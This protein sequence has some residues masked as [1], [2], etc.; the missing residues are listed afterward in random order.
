MTSFPRALCTPRWRRR[1]VL[2]AGLSAVLATA[3]RQTAV[4]AT[5]SRSMAGF[6]EVLFAIAGDLTIEQGTRE[7]LTVEAEPAVLPKITTDV[8]GRR[9][10][11][12][13]G[14]GRI[15]TQQPI[16][17]RLGVRNL[18]VLESRAVGA[19][20][21]GPLRSD[22]L[23]L[24]LAGGGSIHVERLDDA[25]S[26]EVRITGAGDVDVRG[27][28]VKAQRLDIRGMG[29]FSAPGLASESADVAIDG[30]GQ[31][32]VAA[33]TSLAVRI[34]GIGRVR[35]HGDPAVTQSITGIGSID[36]D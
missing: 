10:V 35:Y 11:I 30:N 19:I 32:Q 2:T 26:L 24:V 13:A 25:R 12:G 18:R 17:I 27:G 9:L 4:A 6:D 20:S 14:S 3:F 8:H 15:E 36:K 21:I 31:V 7:S 28:K 29:S 33:S 22:E 1:V 23:A 34:G 5:Q 16:R